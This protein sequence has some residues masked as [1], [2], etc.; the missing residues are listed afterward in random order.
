MK[1]CLL[2][3][4]LLSTLPSAAAAQEIPRGSLQDSLIGWIKVYKFTGPRAPLTVDAKRYS[5]AQLSIVDSL[6]NWMQASYTPKGALGDVLRKVS[7]RLGLYNQDEASLPQSYGAE[8]RTY[9]Q[10]KYDANHKIV[11][12][13]TDHWTWSV[14]AN[15]VFGEPVLALNTPT[16]Y[17]FLLPNSSAQVTPETQRYD[18]SHHPA[19]K[20]FITYFN[21]QSK[22]STVHATYVV[23]SKG[24]K[25]PFVKITKAEYLDKLAGAV[26]RKHDAASWE[27]TGR[28]TPPGC[29]KPPRS[30]RFS[31]TSCWRITRMCSKGAAARASDM[32]CTRSM[33]RW[34]SWRRPTS[35]SGSWYG[36]T[37][38]CSIR[39][40]S[41]RSSPS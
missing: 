21:D 19:L 15:E 3:L 10:L 41:I 13:T 28:D 32:P 17:Y 38:T 23:L 34:P 7:T 27:P 12:Y 40:K 30:S 37:G 9:F 31:P 35:R 39:S 20:P 36:G 4:S 24:N 29:R 22:S 2:L 5:P 16:Q 25:F 1:A 33:R 8:S 14:R 26:A 6:A 11:P 18:Q